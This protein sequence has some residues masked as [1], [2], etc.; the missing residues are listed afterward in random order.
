MRSGDG[1]WSRHKV[2]Q[3]S[4]IRQAYDARVFIGLR[5]CFRCQHKSGRNGHWLVMVDR[6]RL[7]IRPVDGALQAPSCLI[8]GFGQA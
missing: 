7:V 5:P 6:F 2:A 4:Q 8:S 3:A 1:I